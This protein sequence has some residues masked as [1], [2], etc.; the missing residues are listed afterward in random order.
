MSQN[1]FNLFP[2]ASVMLNLDE[3]KHNLMLD[4]RMNIDR[5][6]YTHLN[7]FRIWT[8]ENTF[9]TGNPQLSAAL[10]HEL[11]LNYTFLYMG[12]KTKCTK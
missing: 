12:M 9:S 10:A 6:Y 11:M 2:S 4:Y 5:P 3:G 1:Y 8:T 7:P